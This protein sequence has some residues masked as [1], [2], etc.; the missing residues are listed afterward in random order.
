LKLNAHKPFLK[1]ILQG[2]GII[3]DSETTGYR[4][5]KQY[6]TNLISFKGLTKDTFLIGLG[7][8]SATFGLK[9]FLIPNQFIDGG[10][11]GISL[12]IATLT[13]VPVY[14]LI[15]FINIPFIILGHFTLGKQFAIK[16]AIAITTLAICLATIQFPVVTNDNLLIAIFGGVFLGAGIGLAVRGGAVIDGTEVLA[17]YLSKKGGLTIGDIVLMINGLVF[18][19]AAY[20]LSIEVAMYSMITYIA[21]S[22]TLDFIIEGID[23]YI[24]VT[25]VSS[26][27]E[28]IRKMIIETMGRGVTVYSGK[29]GYGKRGEAKEVDIIYTVITRL[30][31]NKLNTEI[32]K[33]TSTA[34]VVMNTVKETR[35]GMIKKK[36]FKD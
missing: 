5:A 18:S 23:E 10:A 21:A 12:L 9:G 33:I 36:P 28:E 8:I 3:S 4:Q 27:C 32:E 31:I 14:L 16:T 19:S 34:F 25:I 13:N 30:E 7:V 35:G 29:K 20:F 24:G 15:L 26:H 22:K 11:T 6:R 17:I 2:L 1:V